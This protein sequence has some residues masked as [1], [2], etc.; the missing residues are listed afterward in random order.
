MLEI[1]KNMWRRKTRTSL[2][3]FGIAIGIL[4]LVVMG[5]MAEKIQLLVDGGVKY[6]Q[7]KVQIMS[8]A[9]GYSLL[10]L[11]MSVK[12]EIAKIDGV[13]Y[14]SPIVYTTL[15]K[16]TNSVSFGP[17]DSITGGDL[18]ATK[19]ESF[20]LNLKSGR[21]LKIG[22]QGKVVL[23][24]DLVKK[25]GAKLNEYVTI[26][27]KKYQVI[28]VWDKTF[29][30]PDTSV[31]MALSDG[32][33]IVYDDLPALVKPAVKPSDIVS[34]FVAYPKKGVDPNKLA[35]TI[36]E[37]V[38]GVKATGP[39]QF[40][41]QVVAAMQM[42]NSIIYGIAIISLLIGSLSII[43]TMTMSVSERTKEIGI[44]KAVGAKTRTILTEYLT[45][46][47]VIGLFGGIM[48]AG[49]GS[50]IVIAINSAL[51]NSGKD[52]LFLLTPRLLITAVSFAVILGILA[53]IFPA[54]HAT[55]VSIVKALREE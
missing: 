44:K 19:Y 42:F 48:G 45:E 1:L 46:A 36:E 20:K 25:L 23:G 55:R 5:A 4:A 39:K 51:E 53:G 37:T 29:T 26:R 43:N 15:T 34:G 13:Q 32:Q 3:I 17:P 2:T 18:N 24:Y 27:G 38:E 10:P 7:D 9:S 21:E 54:V 11:K 31:S 30:A 16:E 47:G 28:G 14:V 40:Q 35:K 49:I 52:M 41:D 50:L 12:D 6:Y 8:D 33:Q 22:D